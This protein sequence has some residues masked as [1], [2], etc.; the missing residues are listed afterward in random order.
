MFL[1]YTQQTFERT[2][3]WIHERKIFDKRPA[4]LDYAAAV[5]T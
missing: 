1:P 2:Q 3:N 4:E 5:A